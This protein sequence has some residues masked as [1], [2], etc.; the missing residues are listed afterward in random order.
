MSALP[1][2]RTAAAR[3]SF[4]E[5][6]GVT[7][8]ADVATLRAAW[9]LRQ[10]SLPTT[11]DPIERAVALAELREALDVLSDPVR[12]AAYDERLKERAG[13]VLRAHGQALSDPAAQAA[14]RERVRALLGLAPVAVPA[15]TAAANEATA[16]LEPTAPVPLDEPVAARPSW[17][18]RRPWLIGVGTGLSAAVLV[19]ALAPV[20][21]SAVTRELSDDAARAAAAATVPAEAGL[22]VRAHAFDGDP[23]PLRLSG[24][25]PAR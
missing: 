19:L 23:L 22:P 7:A 11:L 20:T 1:L 3:H 18:R 2:P 9:D 21:Q 16:H 15:A 13:Q 24:E 6:L 17:L 5:R 14:D 8:D 10:S 12:R 4:Y 25:L